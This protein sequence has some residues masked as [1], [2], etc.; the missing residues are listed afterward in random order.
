MAAALPSRLSGFFFP[1][2][3]QDPPDEKHQPETSSASIPLTQDEIATL[4]EFFLLLD[5]WDRQKKAA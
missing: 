1:D 5:K 2:Q 3:G 4:R